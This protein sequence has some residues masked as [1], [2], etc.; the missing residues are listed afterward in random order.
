M[1]WWPGPDHLDV[2]F[3]AERVAEGAYLA[4]SAAVRGLDALVYNHQHL[5][6][7]AAAKE[8]FWED[9]VVRA[10]LKVKSPACFCESLRLL[11][12]RDSVDAAT[13]E[14]VT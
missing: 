8:K 1:E 7:A 10:L 14:E 4:A 9:E 13:K 3:S 2:A 5:A 11:P 12:C 6:E